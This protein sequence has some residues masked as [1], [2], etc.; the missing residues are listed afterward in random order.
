[1]EVVLLEPVRKLGKIG[2]IVDVKTGYAKNFL[3]PKKK[4]LRA[5]KD[6]LAVFEAQKSDLHARNQ[7]AKEN[8]EKV[9]ALLVGKSITIVR[10]SSAD[11]KLFGSV[12]SKDIA[13]LLSDAIAPVSQADVMLGDPIKKTGVFKV[14]VS[15]YADVSAEILINIARSADE[16]ASALRAYQASLTAPVESESDS[17]SDT[18]TDAA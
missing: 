6:N 12:T 16:A 18:D 17:D 1:M 11:G 9:V 5:T 10:Q 8:A 7:Q 4:A 15:P 14:E 13:K 2:E 3:L